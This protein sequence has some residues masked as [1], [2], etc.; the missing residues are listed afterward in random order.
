MAKHTPGPWSISQK[1][2][3]P[4]DAYADEHYQISGAP[5]GH[6]APWIAQTYGGLLTGM[7][8]ANAN[9]IAAA[10]SMLALLEKAL[11]II[12]AKANLR[13]DCDGGYSAATENYY[14][15]MRE[16]ANEISVEINK[17]RGGV[18]TDPEPCPHGYGFVEYCED[19]NKGKE[20]KHG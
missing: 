2:T 14:S 15:E 11:P 6:A 5:F 4:D 8:E 19:C 12:E 13:G 3:D 20:A 1:K 16:L 9:L 17:A 18:S 10:P 7:A